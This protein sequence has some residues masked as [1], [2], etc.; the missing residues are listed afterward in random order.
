MDK[1]LGVEHLFWALSTLPQVCAAL[2]AFVG[3]LVLDSLSKIE[4]RSKVLEE[5]IR[6]WAKGYSKVLEK[7]GHPTEMGVRALLFDKLVKI[8]RTLHIEGEI[9][10]VSAHEADLDSWQPLDNWK[11]ATQVQLV[12][13][14]SLNLSVITLSLVLPPFA[15]KLAPYSWTFGIMWC[16]SALAIAASTLGL[17]GRTVFK[18]QP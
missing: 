17:L 12:Y 4:Q 1:P 10:L 9:R 15:R 2:I 3:F 7:I 8:I 18:P 13:F 14:V 6:G 11:K 16:L 5:N